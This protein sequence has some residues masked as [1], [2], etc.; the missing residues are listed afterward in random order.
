MARAIDQIVDAVRHMA[1]ELG[2]RRGVGIEVAEDEAAITVHLRDAL[3]VVI[4]SIQHA[5]VIGAVAD[6]LERAVGCEHPAMI[7]ALMPVRCVAAREGAQ[8]G[9]AVRAAVQDGL[10]AAVAVRVRITD[11]VPMWRTT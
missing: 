4:V 10:H 1:Q 6:E 5:L 3:D 7:G 11:C 9:A 2:Q 8:R